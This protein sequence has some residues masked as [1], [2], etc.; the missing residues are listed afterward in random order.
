MVLC[1]GSRCVGR[2]GRRAGDPGG[3]QVGWAPPTVSG[4]CCS[5]N[6]AVSRRI[7]SSNG[8]P[9]GGIAED[10][11]FRTAPEASSACPYT[12]RVTAAS[13]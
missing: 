3:S 9:S 4:A 11:Y 1:N 12:F 7:L 5:R 2:T 8:S 6:V 13:N 10:F